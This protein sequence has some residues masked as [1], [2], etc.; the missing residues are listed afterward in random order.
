MSLLLEHLHMTCIRQSTEFTMNTGDQETL[1]PAK[2]A[3]KVFGKEQHSKSYEDTQECARSSMF[4][5]FT[6]SQLVGL[7]DHTSPIMQC[8]SWHS[9]LA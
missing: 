5:R 2:Y 1:L 8:H 9:G 6:F 4:R 7:H 3:D